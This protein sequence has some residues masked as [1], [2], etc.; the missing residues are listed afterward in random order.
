MGRNTRRQPS[1]QTEKQRDV[2]QEI[3]EGV[4][5]I[6]AGGGKR[7]VVAPES[8][9]AR[10]RLRSGLSQTEFAAAIGVSKRTIEQWEQGR[11]KPSGA[12]KTLLKIID[13]HPE[14][15]LELAA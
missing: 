12:A 4:R 1:E 13:K 3:L 11:R 8:P 2:W 5:E 15:L 6:K 7:T 10:I 9:V 14:V